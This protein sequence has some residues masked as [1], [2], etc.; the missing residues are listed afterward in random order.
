VLKDNDP[1]TECTHYDAAAANIQQSIP[2]LKLKVNGF[3][4]PLSSV[5]WP[6]MCRRFAYLL[7]N[8]LVFDWSV[9]CF[10]DKMYKP[11]ELCGTGAEECP[12]VPP[13]K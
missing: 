2:G 9:P 11:T 10:M 3:E 6:S 13:K 1:D 8:P 5:L 4:S 12:C 7:N